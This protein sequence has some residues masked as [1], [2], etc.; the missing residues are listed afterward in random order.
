MFSATGQMVPFF[1]FP[2][3]ILPFYSCPQGRLHV[4]A[5]VGRT[6]LE[7]SSNKTEL[8]K[9]LFVGWI[10]G[11]PFLTVVVIAFSPVDMTTSNV[12]RRATTSSDVGFCVCRQN[13]FV[14]DD[15]EMLLKR[16][17]LRR[18]LDAS[19]DLVFVDG[20][21]FS[22]STLSP[23]KRTPRTSTSRRASSKT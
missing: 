5:C 6:F 23:L 11:T 9:P 14:G 19:P 10:G 17:A 22:S 21:V 20:A 15:V 7:R 18:E 12:H 13:V 3:E 16:R 8:T 2:S 4:P 1:L